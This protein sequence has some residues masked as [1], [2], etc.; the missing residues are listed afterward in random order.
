MVSYKLTYLQVRFPELALSL[1]RQGAQV[2]TYPSAWTP[3]TGSHWEPLLRA[4]AIETQSWI[5]AAAQV[6]WHNDKRES[7]GHS[8]IIS[9]WGEI[10]AQLGSANK[11]PEIAVAEI[12]LE[13][14]EKI[15]K[16]VPLLRRT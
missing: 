16:E 4:R 11:E 12:D 9:P 1:R 8:M 13:Q 2:L 14:V 6:G 3:P 15:R 7:Y 10:K 5:V